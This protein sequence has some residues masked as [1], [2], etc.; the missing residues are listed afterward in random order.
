MCIEIIVTISFPL[1]FLF[2][3]EDIGSEFSPFMFTSQ[4]SFLESVGWQHCKTDL[5]KESDPFYF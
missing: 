2:I 5:K 3:I 4:E 1:Q